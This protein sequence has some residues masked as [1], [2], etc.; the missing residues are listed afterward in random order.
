MS[1]DGCSGWY[2]PE[3]KRGGSTYSC[4]GEWSK[5]G[6][7]SFYGAPFIW[8]ALHDFGGTDGLKG[9]L[10]KAA[11]VPFAGLPA[12]GGTPTSVM[13][14]GFTPEGIDHVRAINSHQP[15]LPP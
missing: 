9:A 6:G 14:S 12:A 5:F 13:G 1:E 15:L 11:E 7:A 10:E 2:S 8:T 3:P 4:Q